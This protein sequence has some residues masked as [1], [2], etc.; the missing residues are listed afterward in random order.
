MKNE[1]TDLHAISYG[2]KYV[3]SASGRESTRQGAL[4]A[5]AKN[6]KL[7][8]A[9]QILHGHNDK[10]RIIHLGLQNFHFFFVLLSRK[11]R[12]CL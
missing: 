7:P 5:V 6:E 2:K 3:H 8:I 1:T 12:V 9:Q 4:S 10:K 11:R